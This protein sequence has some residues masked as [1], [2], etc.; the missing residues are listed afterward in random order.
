M[1]TEESSSNN[2]NKNNNW[3]WKESLAFVMAAIALRGSEN[4]RPIWNLL[5]CALWWFVWMFVLSSSSRSVTALRPKRILR[6]F[7]TNLSTTE[8]ELETSDQS[9]TP[10]GIGGGAINEKQRH[11]NN[12]NGGGA[13]EDQDQASSSF[14]APSKHQSHLYHALEGLDRYPNYLARWQP[15]DIDQLEASLEEKL[16]LVRHQKTKVLQERT[17]AA[18]RVVQSLLESHPERE[19]WRALLEPL[20][21]WEDVQTKLLDPLAV[22]AIFKSKMFSSKRNNTNVPTVQAVRKGQVKVQL[23]PERLQAWLDEELYDVYSFRLLQDGFCKDL[24]DFARAFAQ[25]ASEDLDNEKHKLSSRP[26]NLD[27]VG[28]KWV[29]DLLFHLVM[30]PLA[31]ELFSNSEGLQTDLDWRHGYVAGYSA[32]PGKGK[33]R[34]RLVT[35]TDDSEVTMNTCLGDDDFQGGL[36][37]FRG[38]RGTPEE[39]QLVG[40]FEPQRGLGLIH[41]GRHFHDVTQVTAGDR[42]A[43]IVW[44][45]SWKGIRSN[46]CPCCWLNRRQQ[47]DC[48]CESR[49]N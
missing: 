7:L 21:T 38:L 26:F 31:R 35:H 44:A 36:L 25:R 15:E 24:T 43:L 33:P 19:R 13:E 40:T 32:Q 8:Q 3:Q 46:T 16:A 11:Y 29:N 22:T 6:R 9:A 42:F 45:R 34:E 28:L 48:I 12:D 5:I 18:Q 41:A 39:G 20:D 27:L 47:T 49:W 14:Y 10:S 2:N 17:D 23:D 4:R 30:R 37:E 1:R